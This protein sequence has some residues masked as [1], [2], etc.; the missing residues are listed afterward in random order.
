MPCARAFA[1]APVNPDRPLPPSHP[2][3]TTGTRCGTSSRGLAE[4]DAQAFAVPWGSRGSDAHCPHPGAAMLLAG[5]SQKCSRPSVFHH[6]PS[7]KPSLVPPRAPLLSTLEI[8]ALG[9]GTAGLHPDKASPCRRPGGGPGSVPH[10]LCTPLWPNEQDSCAVWG[11]KT[12]VST[13]P[14][15]GL[16]IS[17]PR[18]S[19]VGRLFVRGIVSARHSPHS[20]PVSAFPPPC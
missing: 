9:G 6:V 18:G 1:A 15:W 8:P 19:V 12:T 3:G 16:A 20:S 10:P 7:T 4:A 2:R 5:L 11:A 13:R 14:S 17:A